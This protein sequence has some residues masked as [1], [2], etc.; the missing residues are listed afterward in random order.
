MTQTASSP[1]SHQLTVSPHAATIRFPH[2][3]LPV[4]GYAGAGLAAGFED[5]DP[6]FDPE[7][8]PGDLLSAVWRTSSYLETVQWE[9]DSA[10]QSLV[11][12]VRKAAVAGASQDELCAAANLTPE[13]LR[14]ALLESPGGPAA[15]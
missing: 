14:A 10:Q 1:R 5:A 13:E 2:P 6:L 9:L 8:A 12:A 15:I 3:N 4:P 11:Q 7:P